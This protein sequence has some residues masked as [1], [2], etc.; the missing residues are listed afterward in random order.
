M[1]R[2]G[3]EGRR[4]PTGEEEVVA[5]NLIRR[6]AAGTLAVAACAMAAAQPAA[7]QSPT[8]SGY[9]ANAPSIQTR[10]DAPKN[11]SLPFTGVDVGLIVG[12]GVVLSGAGLAL[13]RITLARR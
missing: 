4:G 5:V 7:A 3:V 13:R 1:A 6:R 10:V 8:V 9:S 11:S 12:A 2:A